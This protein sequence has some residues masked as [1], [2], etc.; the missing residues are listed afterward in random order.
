VAEEWARGKD[1]ASLVAQGPRGLCGLF[2]KEGRR[3][4]GV[5]KRHRD[6]LRGKEEV[7]VLNLPIMGR[8]RKKREN[9]EREATH[10]EGSIK[11]SSLRAKKKE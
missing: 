9:K 11:G 6:N 8:K 3:R 10:Y 4:V 5:G 1:Q 2:R 7:Q